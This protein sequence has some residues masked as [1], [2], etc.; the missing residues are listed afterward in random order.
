[1]P[2]N[3]PLVI[4]LDENI[5]EGQRMLLQAWGIAAPVPDLLQ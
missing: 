4:I 3:R 5:I 2:H 1:M